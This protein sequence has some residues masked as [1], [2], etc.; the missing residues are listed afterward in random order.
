MQGKQGQTVLWAPEIHFE[1]YRGMI[2]LLCNV[3]NKMNIV[4]GFPYAQWGEL[5]SLLESYF[6]LFPTTTTFW[7]Q[8]DRC[9]SALEYTLS[10]FRY[11]CWS[12]MILSIYSTS[13]VMCPALGL[14]LWETPCSCRESSQG[15][16][17]WWRDLEAQRGSYQCVQ[18][19]EGRVQGRWSQTLQCCP[20]TGQEAVGTNWNTETHKVSS[21]L[22]ET[23]FFFSYWHSLPRE[24]VDSPVSLGDLEKLWCWPSLSRC[25]YL[26]RC[27][28]DCVFPGTACPLWTFLCLGLWL[29]L[30]LPPSLRSHL[31]TFPG[32]EFLPSQTLPS[33]LASGKPWSCRQR[34]RKKEHVCLE[35]YQRRTG[36]TGRLKSFLAAR[37][38]GV[39]RSQLMLL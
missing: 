15:P 22:Q 6:F 31:H 14:L 5:K 24:V 2:N 26:C 30:P 33:A 16:Q 27:Y 7:F 28:P 19:P 32:V 38:W 39:E 10:L 8:G 4:V 25:P 20:M 23:F 37:K 9:L 29:C 13:G 3:R 36:R 1:Y 12:E 21:N 35:S 17:R 18:I 11:C 34:S